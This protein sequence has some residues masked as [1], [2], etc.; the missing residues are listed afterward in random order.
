MESFSTRRPLG[1]LELKQPRLLERAWHSCF[2]VLLH[3]AT[4]IRPAL[5]A[6]IWA[7]EVDIH[8][9]VAVPSSW[10]CCGLLNYVFRKR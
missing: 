1:T 8:S 4:S 2:S 3:R 9:P 7:K 10:F 6:T 5:P